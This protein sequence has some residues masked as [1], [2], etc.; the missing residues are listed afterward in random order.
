MDPRD[1]FGF[2]VIPELLDREVWRSPRRL[3]RDACLDQTGGPARRDHVF[4][5]PAPEDEPR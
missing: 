3:T 2:D 5:D 1:P 4:T